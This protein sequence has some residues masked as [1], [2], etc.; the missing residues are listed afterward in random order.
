[1]TISAITFYIIITRF[2]TDGAK[3]FKLFIRK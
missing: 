3:G 1:L 2:I